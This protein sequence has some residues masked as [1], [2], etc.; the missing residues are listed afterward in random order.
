MIAEMIAWPNRRVRDAGWESA[1]VRAGRLR[2]LL[3]PSAPAGFAREQRTYASLAQASGLQTVPKP[4]R[5]RQR[6]TGRIPATAEGAELRVGRPWLGGAQ[7][8]RQ[9]PD[10]NSREESSNGSGGEGS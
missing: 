9:R 3:D 4:P 10:S 6:G 2:Q 7:E 1:Q 5:P 8:E